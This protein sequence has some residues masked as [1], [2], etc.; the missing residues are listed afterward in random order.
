[1]KAIDHIALV[2]NDMD[3]AIALYEEALQARFYLRETNEEQGFEVAAFAVGEAHIEL[4]SPTTPD[5]VIGRF[6]RKRGPGIHHIAVEVEEIAEH[7][8]RLRGQGLR[9][10]S[11]T[12]QRGT[13]GSRIAFIHP[14]SLLG[15]LVELVELPGDGKAR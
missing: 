11:D 6:L 14:K 15:T 1:L 12:I 2:V 5:S 7:V 10:T 4:L 3:E 9:L 13:G 8:R